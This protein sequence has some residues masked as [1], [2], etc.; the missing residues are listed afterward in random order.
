MRGRQTC[1][2]AD[3]KFSPD[4]RAHI[5]RA[6][7]VSGACMHMQVQMEKYERAAA[8]LELAN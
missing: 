3:F 2:Q 4:S 6:K 1:V 7:I 8:R 5:K